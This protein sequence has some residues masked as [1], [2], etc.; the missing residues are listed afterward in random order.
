MQQMTLTHQASFERYTKK[1]RREQFLE[2]M[3][4]VMPWSELLALVEPHYAKGETGQKWRSARTG[5]SRVCGPR[6]SG[7]PEFFPNKSLWPYRQK[8]D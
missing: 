8:I 4:A 5:T 6:W 7:H 1:T 2:E 3:D